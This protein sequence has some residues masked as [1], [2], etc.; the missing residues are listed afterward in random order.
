MQKSIIF[1]LH[2]TLNRDLA[3]ELVL[4]CVCLC[5]PNRVS[6]LRIMK[7]YSNERNR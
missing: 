7:S 1:G 3:H 5:D 4:N 2:S 6:K